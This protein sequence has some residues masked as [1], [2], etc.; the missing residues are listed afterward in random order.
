MKKFLASILAVLTV[1][2]MSVAPVTAMASGPDDDISICSS[3]Y[4]G[5]FNAF[6][7]RGAVSGTMDVSFIVTAPIRASKIG[8][9]QIEI[10]K[11]SGAHVTTIY[12]STS[13][14]LLASNTSMHSGSYTF[15]GTPG[16]EYC[17]KVTFF[18]SNAS[19]SDST[20]M[21]TSSVTV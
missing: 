9:S 13:N 18:S 1:F 3:D 5:S 20:T 2:S 19:G 15:T 10:I 16:V 4:I 6:A 17:A 12:G 8:V 7:Q 21:I 11:A 14:G